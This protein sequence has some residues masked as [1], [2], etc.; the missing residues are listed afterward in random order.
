MTTQ[1][2]DTQ[3][4]LQNLIFAGGITCIDGLVDWQSDTQSR[5][6][7]KWLNQLGYKWQNIQKEVFTE[8]H[9]QPDVIEYQKTFLEEM[10]AS[11]LYLV[12]FQEDGSILDKQ[13]PED[14]T[15]GKPNW[16]PIIMIT[17]DESIFSA[18]DSCQ[19]TWVQKRH[20]IL[21]PKRKEKELWSLIFYFLGH[22]WT[23]FY[24]QQTAIE[25][26]TSGIPAEPATYFEYGNN[27]EKY[28]M[29]DHLL[30]QI[31]DKA[32]S[33]AEALYLGYK[34]WFMF[35]NTTNHSVYAKDALC[36]KNINENQGGQQFFLRP[37]WYITPNDKT[38]TQNMW[39][40]NNNAATGNAVQVQK[41]IQLVLEEQGLW[42]QKEFRL[43]CEKPKCLSCEEMS[44]CT[45]CVQG[46]KCNLC[47]E[48]KKPHSGNCLKQR[49]CDACNK[50][51]NNANVY[52][53]ST[54]YGIKRKIHASLVRSARSFL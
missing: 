46:Q 50:Q 8:G 29:R 48:E 52:R 43:E 26:I 37:S 30:Q 28:W 12:K 11:L 53:K 36:V 35:D 15:V 32:L 1:K 2:I 24:I 51:K 21:R 17:H 42:P 54:V 23:F 16:Q 44:N 45:L 19:S 31:V 34:L 18:N 14:C 5:T 13:Y 27:N 9:K 38:K 22:V 47:K 41:G 39:V 6:A 4:E 20:D 49:I 25:K 7:R 3:E 33:A 40:Y 10:S